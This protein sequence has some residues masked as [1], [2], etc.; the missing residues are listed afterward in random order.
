MVPVIGRFGFSGYGASSKS[1][2]NPGTFTARCWGCGEELTVPVDRLERRASKKQG[3]NA[4][5]PDLR[6]CLDCDDSIKRNSVREMARA[7]VGAGRW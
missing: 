1:M 2:P 5:V 7:L 6:L 3:I 4:V